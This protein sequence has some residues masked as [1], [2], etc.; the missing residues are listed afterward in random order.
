MTSRHTGKLTAMLLASLAT[1]FAAEYKPANYSFRGEPPY[2]GGRAA[3]NERRRK[4]RAERKA[5]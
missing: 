5:T 4:E 2:K 3:R 1:T